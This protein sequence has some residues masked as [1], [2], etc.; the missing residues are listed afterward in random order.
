MALPL[1][2]RGSHDEG[3]DRHLPGLTMITKLA[4]TVFLSAFL[5]LASAGAGPAPAAVAVGARLAFDGGPADPA[6]PVTVQR[7][8]D[9]KTFKTIS[10][11]TPAADGTWKTALTVETT[12]AYRASSAAGTSQA[13]RLI[14][15]IRRVL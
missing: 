10:T 14:V 15:G 5:L 4:G 6:Q 3:H 8:T 2:C 12:G 7:S 1:P 11:V 9:G 13:R